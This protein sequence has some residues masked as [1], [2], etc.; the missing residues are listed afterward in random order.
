MLTGEVRES[1]LLEIDADIARKLKKKGT[2]IFVFRAH[3]W[4]HVAAERGEPTGS[5]LVIMVATG[6]D[7][8]P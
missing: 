3:Q 4:R 5:M 7:E 8:K 1:L 6:C 2:Y